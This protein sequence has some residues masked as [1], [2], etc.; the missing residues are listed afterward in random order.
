M[1]QDG[2]RN[3]ISIGGGGGFPVG[4]DQYNGSGD[5]IKD[6]TGSGAFSA[7]Y[8]FRIFRYL[9]PEI[10]VVTM[11]SKSSYYGHEMEPSV[12]SYSGRA[13]LVS[14]G[15]RVLAPVEPNGFEL[16]AGGGGAYLNTTIQELN[17]TGETHRYW[18]VQGGF[19]AAIDRHRRH[20]WLGPT[21]RY[22]RGAG[23]VSQPWLS[24]TLDLG[25]RF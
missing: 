19:R 11:S 15:A 24:V 8:E 16:F 3:T 18:Q 17:Y 6:R 21:V 12:Y 20:F 1:G 9:A 22:S 7:G 23:G 10:G 13:T 25:Y 5:Q 4:G 2:G 14:F